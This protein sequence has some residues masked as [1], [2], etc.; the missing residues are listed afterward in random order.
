MGDVRRP[1]GLG[2]L[3]KG[4]R[5]A[6]RFERV[7]ALPGVTGGGRG[8]L[9]YGVEDGVFVVRVSKGG[10]FEDRE[11]GEEGRTG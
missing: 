6:G 11:A 9:G 8:G 3:V 5:K 2:E 7:V 4:E 10:G 1:E